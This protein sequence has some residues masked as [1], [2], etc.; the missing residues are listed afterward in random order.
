M[1]TENHRTKL[2][3]GD[4][5]Y[6]QESKDECDLC[7]LMYDN[8]KEEHYYRQNLHSH[9]AP[10]TVRGLKSILS[11][12]KNRICA[13]E[14]YIHDRSNDFEISIWADEGINPSAYSSEVRD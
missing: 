6:L 9:R 11:T 5:P 8:I 2:R 3:V 13:A 4:R 12:D 14:F 1:Y 10:L 7:R